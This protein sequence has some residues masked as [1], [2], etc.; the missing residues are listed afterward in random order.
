MDVGEEATL[1][2]WMRRPRYGRGR[3]G[4]ATDVDEE[5]ILWMWMRRPCYGRGGGSHLLLCG[6]VRE[7]KF[8]G[9][10]ITVT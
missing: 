10:A 7:M 2:M 9:T 8:P 3:G 5:A 6:L 4:H 1:W